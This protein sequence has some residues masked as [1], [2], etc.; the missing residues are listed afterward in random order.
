MIE[1]SKLPLVMYRARA[2]APITVR[3]TDG[4]VRVYAWVYPEPELVCELPPHEG[5]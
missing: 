4:S 2:A 3:Y 5:T 1:P